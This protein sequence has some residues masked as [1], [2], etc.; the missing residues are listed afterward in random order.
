MTF[1]GLKHFC[2]MDPFIHQKHFLKLHFVIALL[3]K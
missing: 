1:L 2:L 3:L